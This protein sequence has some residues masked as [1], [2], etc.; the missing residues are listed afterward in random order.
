VVWGELG[1]AV[2]STA[3]LGI[4]VA[5]GEWAAVPFQALFALGFVLVA[6]SSLRQV[7]AVRQDR[8]VSAP[9]SSPAA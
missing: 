5:L 6:A 3:G 4:T 9:A 2:Y 7:L 1:L 8:T